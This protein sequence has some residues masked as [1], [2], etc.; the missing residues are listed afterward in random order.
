MWGKTHLCILL[1]KGFAILSAMPQRPNAQRDLVCGG[2]WHSRTHPRD[3][4]LHSGLA[5]SSCGI[6]EV[7]AS[8]CTGE[9]VGSG[10]IL[11]KISS[12]K[13]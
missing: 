2:M 13:E 4:L 11:G 8:S 6:Q 1:S 10:W 7:M 9:R 12:Q 5:S 3:V